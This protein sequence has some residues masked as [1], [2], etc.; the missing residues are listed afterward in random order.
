MKYTDMGREAEEEWKKETPGSA[1]LSFDY[2]RQ[3]EVLL[4]V[5]ETIEGYWAHQKALDVNLFGIVNEGRDD[6]F[7]FSY[8][9]REGTK[10]GSDSVCSMI[11]TL[12]R[13]T[14]FM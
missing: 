2:P 10:S 11:F 4:F 3:L 1:M 12:D 8:L 6:K 7:R 13:N 9:L 14:W 5:D